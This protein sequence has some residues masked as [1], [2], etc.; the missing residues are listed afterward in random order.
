[1]TYY[2]PQLIQTMRAALDTA[3]SRGSETSAGIQR[4]DGAPSH[5][6]LRGAVPGGPVIARSRPLCPGRQQ[7]VQSPE[8]LFEAV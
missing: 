3:M 4:T 7:S 8:H 1:M 5:G 2:S 6:E